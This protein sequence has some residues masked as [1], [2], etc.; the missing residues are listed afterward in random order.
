MGTTAL[1]VDGTA[2]DAPEKKFVV[3]VTVFGLAKVPIADS[4]DGFTA[5]GA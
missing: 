2:D 5:L 4:R 3:D 1:D